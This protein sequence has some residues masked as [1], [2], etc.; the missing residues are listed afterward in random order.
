MKVFFLKLGAVAVFFSVVVLLAIGCSQDAPKHQHKVA[1]DSVHLTIDTTTYITKTQ[2]GM[3]TVTEPS[4]APPINLNLW[5]VTLKVG[6]SVV[7]TNL[8]IPQ[9]SPVT[10]LNIVSAS[11]GNN[12]PPPIPTAAITDQPVIVSIVH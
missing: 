7:V 4:G 6:P 5:N 1:G 10:I 3:L 8:I 11:G 9:G 2:I 12:Y